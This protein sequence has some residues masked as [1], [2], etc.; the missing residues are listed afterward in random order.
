MKALSCSAPQESKLGPEL[1]SNYTKPLGNLMT[2]LAICYHCYADD[3][4]MYKSVNP[5]DYAAQQSCKSYMENCVQQISGWMLSNRLQLNQEKTEFIVFASRFTSRHI[6]VDSL[7]L[8]NSVIQ[9]S[10]VVRNLGVHLDYQLNMKRHVHE[11]RKTCFYYMKWIWSIRSMLTMEATKYLVH[12]LIISRL[13]YCNAILCD[14]PNTVIRELQSVQNAAARLIVCCPRDSSITP[15]L[16][17][18]HWLPIS[19]RIQYK[20]LCL[21]YKGQNGLAPEYIK[22][23]L[24]SYAPIRRLRSSDQKLLTVP[25]TNLAYGKR[26][27]SVA[28]PRL[29]NSLPL[30]IRT[31]DTYNVF[32]KNLKTHLFQCAYM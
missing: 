31:C 27:F 10:D 30:S 9:R 22:D 26:S 11:T 15:I 12:A 3:T 19:H 16:K 8:T 4:Q 7:Q 24:C 20:V 14:L 5:K 18:L 23:M 17:Q 2:I 13:D 28:A 1:Y 6:Q 32:R 25:S 21:T 29:W